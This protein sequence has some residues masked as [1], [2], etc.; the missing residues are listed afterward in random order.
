MA[1]ET[2]TSPA[3]PPSCRGAHLIQSRVK[4][5]RAN[6]RQWSD[7]Q[8]VGIVNPYQRLRQ[9]WRRRVLAGGREERTGAG[10]EPI[11]RICA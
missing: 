4:V 11:G 9:T 6:T 8:H 3:H 1:P 7:P 2:L 10:A 5:G